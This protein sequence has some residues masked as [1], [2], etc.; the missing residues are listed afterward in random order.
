MA[1]C[2][3]HPNTSFYN[4]ITLESKGA[5]SL[6]LSDHRHAVALSDTHNEI[7]IYENPRCGRPKQHAW[8]LRRGLE[9]RHTQPHTAWQKLHLGYNL[10]P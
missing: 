1:L 2:G 5:H 7:A 3:W 4:L 9:W 6:V 8:S 10:L